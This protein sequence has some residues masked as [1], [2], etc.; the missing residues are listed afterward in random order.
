MIANI[1]RFC[2]HD[3]SG[4]RTTVFFKGCPLRCQWCSNPEAQSPES[5]T[6]RRANGICD[7]TE[8]LCG[9]D[10]APEEMLKVVL[11]D[12]PFY[13]ASGGG[14]TLSG[15]EPLMQPELA[16]NLL[17][18]ARAAGISTCI[19]TS[20]HAPF[21][22]MTA[23]LPYLDEIFFDFKHADT[24]KH[25]LYTG[26]GCELIQI[27]I[28]KLL[29]MRPDAKT[30]IPVIPGFNDSDDDIGL[31]CRRLKC[32][33]I[34]S[35]ELMPYHNLATG[36]YTALNR[37]CRFAGVPMMSDTAVVN[38]AAKFEKHGIRA[39]YNGRK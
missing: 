7:S 22:N 38:T 31:M 23:L 29:G 10:M 20:L 8:E 35:V 26:Q 4:I 17:T 37:A 28:E 9:I 19:E 11:R 24:E 5:E 25:S 13:E 16:L 14:M 15:G 39:D 18:G 30:R 3:G 27:N 12:R 34:E 32:L 33:G 6:M 36:K 21:E 2:I 1:Q